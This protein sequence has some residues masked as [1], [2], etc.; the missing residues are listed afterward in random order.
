MT[1]PDEGRDFLLP[2]QLDD[3]GLRG[4][5]V[6]LGSVADRVVAAHGY[7]E[8]VGTLLSQSLALAA[9]MGGGLKY[10]GVFTFQ[11][12][13]DG[14]V[15]MLVA[16]ITSEGEMRGYASFD[17]ARIGEA[18]AGALDQPL[19]PS[20][21]GL[22]DAAAP[23]VPRLLGAGY[24]AFTVDQGP[25]TE[26]YQG[27]VDLSGTTLTDCVQRYLRQS[28]QIDAAI[29]VAARREGCNGSA[30]WH[31]GAIM[32][33]RLPPRSQDGAHL[34]ADEEMEENWRRV[35][36]LLGSV[37]DRELLADDVTPERLLLRL[38]RD[39]A[40]RV[41]ESRPLVHRCRCSRERVER[42]LAAIPREELESLKIDGRVEVVCQFCNTAYLFDDADLDALHPT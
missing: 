16:D 9:V 10:D 21:A 25:D 1:M 33:Q 40:V 27:I 22:A 41:F 29:H 35:S 24:L 13:G 2:F 38:F 23:S 28:E 12:K 11:T 17:A 7:P 30:R 34:P 18:A 14:P 39:D 36:I 15:S 32:M 37:T 4:R 3:L 19:R 20:P 5:I 31:A 42:T 26:R 6:R 8:P